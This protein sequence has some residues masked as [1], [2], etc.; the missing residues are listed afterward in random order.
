MRLSFC[1]DYPALQACQ[2]FISRNRV[3][4]KIDL[5]MYIYRGISHLTLTANFFFYIRAW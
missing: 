1:L 2:A 5:P 4:T 3:F